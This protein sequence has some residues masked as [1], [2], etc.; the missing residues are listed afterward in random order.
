MQ[1]PPSQNLLGRSMDTGNLGR[2]F[3]MLSILVTFTIIVMLT[4]LRPTTVDAGDKAMPHHRQ[5]TV[6]NADSMHEPEFISP[7]T[8]IYVESIL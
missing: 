2:D 7:I 1:A 4:C 3:A 8:P 6:A 5:Q